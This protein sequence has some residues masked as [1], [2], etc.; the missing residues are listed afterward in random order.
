MKPVLVII[1][2]LALSACASVQITAADVQ[3]I[4]DQVLAVQKVGA[5]AYCALSPAAQAKVIAVIRKTAP[6]A[7]IVCASATGGPLV[8]GVTGW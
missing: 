3:R 6:D 4:A 7:N 5:A 8:T 1:A 2:A